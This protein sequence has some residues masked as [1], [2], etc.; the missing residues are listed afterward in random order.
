MIKILIYFNCHGVMLYFLFRNYKV[1]KD[2]KIDIIHNFT[3]LNN[4]KISEDHLKLVTECD[5][6]IYQ[7][8]NNVHD[9]PYDNTNIMKLLK[10]FLNN[11]N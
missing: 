11:I 3:N 2:M 5:I 9:S 4:K 1:T 8:F 10:N 6:F 7:H